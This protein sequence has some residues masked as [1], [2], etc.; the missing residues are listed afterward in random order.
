MN[1][2]YYIKLA[3]TNIRKNYQTYIPY[4]LSCIGMIIMFYN[5]NFV[6]YAKEI[7]TDH[8]SLRMILKLGILVVAFFSII[9]MFYANSF[10]IKRRKKEF[11]LFNILGMEKKHIAK[12]MFYE[13]A[14]ICLGCLAAG[15]VSGIILSKLM[16]LLLLKIISFKVSFGFEVPPVAVITTVV[17]FGLIFLA[18]LIY[19]VFQ[20]HLANPIELIK[21]SNVGEKEP[22]TKWFS[23]IIGTV[24]LSAGYYI[25]LTV[26]S[27]IKAMNLFFIA[28]ILVIIGT[29]YLF[30]AGSIAILKMLRKNKKYYYK[31]NHFISVSGMIYRMKRN[32]VGLA[33]ICILS[34]MVIVML[35]TTVSLYIGFEEVLRNR[36]PRNIIIDVD[37]DSDSQINDMEKLVEAQVE[38]YNTEIKNLVKYN[39]TDYLTIHD[40]EHFTSTRSYSVNK[41]AY[42]K[43]ITLDDYNRI[44]KNT[45]SLNHGE[46]YVCPI[47]GNITGDVLDFNGY[48]LQIKGQVEPFLDETETTFGKS[49][50]IIVDSTD[51][52]KELHSKLWDD[53]FRMS[54]YYAFDLDADKE[55]HIKLTEGLNKNVKMIFDKCYVDGAEISREY[56]YTLY[57][58]LLYLGIFLGL[59][60]I[61]ETVL[62]IYYK[63]ITEGYDDRER[64]EIMQKVG[65]SHQEVKKAVHSQ[66]LTVFFLPLVTAI[67]H[68]AFA[69][70]VITKLLSALNLT[71]VPLYAICTVVSIIVFA[72]FYTVVYS[73]TAKSYYKIVRK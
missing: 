10:L 38:K 12:I 68:L 15:I 32:A 39:Y 27:P 33:N 46:A 51:T 17:L 21:S 56:F 11:G 22:K 20:V 73:I 29:D 30:T 7:G 72:I 34:T 63:Q 47:L 41:M 23:A 70:K 49:F 42:I 61:M 1:N 66:V 62:I 4:I 40:G 50:L 58:G 18:T 65:M 3:A 13:T 24:S 8:A 69:F 67:I 6:S 25:A 37:F 26:E 59:L 64:F 52:M 14:I 57:G 36:Y 71:N 44:T 43:F 31:A 48:K 28:V 5:M 54:Y 55:T 19:N 45:A 9:F 35:S 16:I 2:R 53:E 60:F